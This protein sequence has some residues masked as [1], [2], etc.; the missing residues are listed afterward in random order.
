[1]HLGVGPYRSSDDI[2]AIFALMPCDAIQTPDLPML[3]IDLHIERL[4]NLLLAH[5]L[6][7]NKKRPSS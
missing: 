5:G 1:M 4:L 3:E 6:L 7:K 2:R